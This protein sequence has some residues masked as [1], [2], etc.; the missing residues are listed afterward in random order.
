[1]KL[2]IGPYQAL[3]GRLEMR[4]QDLDLVVQR[5]ALLMTKAEETADDGYLDGV[6]LIYTAFIPGWNPALRKLPAQLMGLY[7]P[8]PTGIR[9]CCSRW[10]P[11]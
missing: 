3:A 9:N 4:I 7:L 6:A 10:Q 2:E 1:M 11:T 8:G 5:I